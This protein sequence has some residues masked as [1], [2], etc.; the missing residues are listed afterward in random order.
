MLLIN[1]LSTLAFNGTTTTQD[2]FPTLV[3]SKRLT[4]LAR[5]RYAQ[6]WDDAISAA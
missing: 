3:P 5:S 1:E 6:W 4:A 2:V